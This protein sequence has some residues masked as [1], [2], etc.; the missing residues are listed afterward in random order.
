MPVEFLQNNLRIENQICSNTVAKSGAQM[1]LI[2]EKQEV[3]DLSNCL[4]K[5][6]LLG[7]KVSR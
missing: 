6:R 4:F 3:E 7:L 1:V 5:G 2:A